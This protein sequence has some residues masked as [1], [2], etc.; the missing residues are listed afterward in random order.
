MTQAATILSELCMD[1]GHTTTVLDLC[2]DLEQEK[3]QE[4]PLA[5]MTVLKNLQ[6]SNENIAYTHLRMS[7]YEYHALKAY[8]EKFSPIKGIRPFAEDLLE[9]TIAPHNASL[10]SYFDA[11]IENKLPKAKQA[12]FRA[13]LTYAKSE[14]TKRMST[15][16]GD[17]MMSMYAIYIVCSIINVVMAVFFLVV[18]L[19]FIFFLLIGIAVFAVEMC[20][21][22]A[23]NRLYGNRLGME[24][25]E[26]ILLCT[27]LATV[28]FAIA[29]AIIGALI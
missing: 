29:A 24:K 15:G 16:N 6:P 28:P 5:I 3:D 25:P 17:G 8:L 26:L 14:Y 19:R 4:I 27:F 13:K 7:G 2:L 9:N 22:F 1:P 12:E 10:L 20:V 11:F 18:D 21:V 23:H